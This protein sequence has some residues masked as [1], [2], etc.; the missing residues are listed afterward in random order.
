MLKQWQFDVLFFVGVGGT[1]LLLIGP[2]IGLSVQSDNPL[3]YTGIGAILT[4]VLTQRS[5]LVKDK[6]D[7]ET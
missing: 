3:T 7:E 6:K 1:V 4:F 5:R 2:S